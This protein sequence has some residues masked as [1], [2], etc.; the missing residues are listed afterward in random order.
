[1]AEALVDLAASDGGTSKLNLLEHPD[2]AVLPEL[3][4]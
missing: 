2:R 4:E 1:M 3:R